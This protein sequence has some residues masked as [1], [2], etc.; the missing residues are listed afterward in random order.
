MAEQNK[1][2]SLIPLF[3]ILFIDGMGLGLLFPVLNSLIVDAHESFLPARYSLADRELLYGATIG[4][5]MIC[6]FFGAT[7]LGDLS[8]NIG[9][10][11]SLLICL[12]GTFLG[13]VL[14]A[15][16]IILGQFPLLVIGRVIAG[17]TAG[18]QPI[19]QAAIIDVSKGDNSV[20]NLG[21]ILLAVSL[22]FIAGP[23]IGGI[24]SDH[25]LYFRLNFATP[26][27]FAAMLSLINIFLLQS[28]FHETLAAPEKKISIKFSHALK[29]FISAFRHKAISSYSVVFLMFIFGWST[30]FSF[31]SMYL[32]QVYQYTTLDNSLF[33]GVMGLGFMAGS[34][35]GVNYFAM[36]YRLDKVI[37]ASLSLCSAAV[38][39]TLGTQP[40]W[41]SWVATFFIGAG[42]CTAYSIL[43]VIF[44]NL[45]SEKEQGWVMGVT[46]SIMA[47]CF[48]VTDFFT[49]YV[50]RVGADTPIA[51]SALG[52]VITTLLYALLRYRVAQSL[53]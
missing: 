52:L 14:S 49:G 15:L 41:I 50:A 2:T 17:F 51:L 32:F 19:A 47:L 33:L 42:V 45:V 16:S 1:S 3:L 26:F 28:F 43:L 25:E 18:S 34:F 29:L 48:G 4:V 6:W 38:L 23:I 53:K 35:I 27:Y 24:L 37:I 11:K 22:G 20:K 13:Y 12:T 5:F 44:S 9:R 39:I 31:I 30:Y 8:D 21:F 36:Y 40:V 7:I 46:G 10:K